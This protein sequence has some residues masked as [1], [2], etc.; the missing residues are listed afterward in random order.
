EVGSIKIGN[1]M[2]FPKLFEFT[3]AILSLPH[4]SATTERIFS[5]LNLIKTKLRNRLHIQLC[6]A[7]LHVKEILNNT[8]YCI[9]EPSQEYY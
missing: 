1:E 3:T 2:V 6:S 9:W 5:N 4:S 7:L 8:E